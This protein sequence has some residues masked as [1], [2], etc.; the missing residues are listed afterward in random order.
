MLEDGTYHTVGRDP[1][2]QVFGKEHGGRTRGVAPTVGVRKALGWVKGNKERHEV[3]DMEAI[4]EMVTKKVTAALGDKFDR[5][6]KEMAA[7]KTIMEHIQGSSITSDGYSDGLDDL[8]VI[9]L[10]Y[11]FYIKFRP[12]CII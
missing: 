3:V 5:Q 8:K 4:E 12:K 7:L 9:M 10:L 6:E 1:I 2:T 11:M